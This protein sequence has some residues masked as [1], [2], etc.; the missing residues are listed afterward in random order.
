MPQP[1]LSPEERRRSA[2][3][4]TAKYSGLAF[5]LLGSCL[6]GVFIGRWLDERMH[7]ERPLWAVFLT[8]LF[9]VASLYV[10]YKQL[11]KE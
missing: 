8:V 2:I 5:Q 4:A 11:L 9:M 10:I 3:R 6:A 1:K 7:L